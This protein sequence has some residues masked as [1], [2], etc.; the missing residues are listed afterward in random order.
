MLWLVLVYGWGMI[1]LV[2]KMLGKLQMG[3]NCYFRKEIL[4]T[5]SQNDAGMI[6]GKKLTGSPQKADKKCMSF[7]SLQP[8][9]YPSSCHCWQS[10][11]R[12]P[13]ARQKRN[14]QDSSLHNHKTA[15][16]RLGLELKDNS[17]IDGSALKW[18]Y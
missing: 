15:S 11:T 16:I 2:L 1:K 14:L 6:I 3:F 12:N 8:F 9:R 18:Q 10:L 4:Q 17:L 13:L 5:K 7:L